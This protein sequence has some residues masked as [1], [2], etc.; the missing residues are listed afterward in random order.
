MANVGKSPKSLNILA[1]AG[2][3]LDVRV[4]IDPLPTDTTGWAGYAHIGTDPVVTK[5]TVTINDGVVRIQTSA[6]NTLAWQTE[7][8]SNKKWDLLVVDNAGVPQYVAAGFVNVFHT[9]TRT[10]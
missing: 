6:A 2:E 10:D 9:I 5:L 8:D 3:P 7:W 4:T 1:V